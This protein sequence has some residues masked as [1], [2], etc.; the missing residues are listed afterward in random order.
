[1][2]RAT[3]FAIGRVETIIPLVSSKIQRNL[4]HTNDDAR[5]WRLPPIAPSRQGFARGRIDDMRMRRWLIR[6]L[7]FVGLNVLY[8]AGQRYVLR[9][10]R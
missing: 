4:A 7:A 1:M 8:R 3:M 6:M 2:R 10:L 9:R 5:A